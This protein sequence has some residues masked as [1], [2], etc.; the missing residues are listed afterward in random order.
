MLVIISDI[1]LTDGTAGQTIKAGAFEIFR[2]ALHDLATEASWRRPSDGAAVYKPISC[3]DV[4]LLGDILDVIRSAR[5]CAGP[6]RPWGDITDPRFSAKVEEITAGILDNNQEALQILKS[7]TCG[8]WI[9]V[10][11]AARLREGCAAPSGELKPVTVQIHYMVGNH[12]WVYHLPGPAFN[13]IRGQISQ[14]IG[15]AN[16]ADSI[17]PYDPR[18]S[19]IVERV[20]REHEVFA[21]HGDYY[22]GENFDRERNA[23]SLGDAIVVELLG[24]FPEQVEAHLGAAL[25]KECALGLREIDNVRP[26]EFVPAWLDA[27]LDKT[28]TGEQAEAVKEIWNQIADQFLGVDFVRKHHSLVK[29]GLRFSS[30]FSLE[31]LRQLV[32]WGKRQLMK[33]GLVGGDFY[34]HAGREDQF[35][36]LTARFIVYGHTHHHEI[37]PLRVTQTQSGPVSQIY[38]NSGTWRAIHEP[39]R[40]SGRTEDFVGY[41]VMSYLAFF[42][43]DERKGHS[44]ESWSGALDSSAA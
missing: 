13:R 9:R 24:R 42:K 12:D 40:L 39:T 25:P 6:V 38:M 32:P 20:L 41:H 44:F 35:K 36:D 10:P 8:Q 17:F 3:V 4:V 19:P 43:G 2:E 28:C 37:V 14:A 27:L 15:L 5:W 23:S 34:P 30:G 16:P 11:A 33:A 29:W 26:V 7:M 18:E 31:T 21:R 1:H 22:D